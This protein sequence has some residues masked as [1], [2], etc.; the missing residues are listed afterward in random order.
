MVFQG[1]YREAQSLT[2]INTGECKIL[3]PNPTEYRD[4]L[5]KGLEG[6]KGV[7]FILY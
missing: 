1:C 2:P 7:P 5:K 6:K 3:K 4:A